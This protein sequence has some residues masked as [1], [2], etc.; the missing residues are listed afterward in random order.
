MKSLVVLS[1]SFLAVI[2]ICKCVYGEWNIIFSGN[3]AMC[4]MLVFTAFWH[5]KFPNCVSMMLPDFIPLKK[6]V[7]YVTGVLEIILGITL[8]IP[9]YRYMAGIATIIFFIMVMPAN[10]TAA[11]KQVDFINA[12]YNNGKTVNYLWFRIPLQLFLLSWVFHFS[13]L[14]EV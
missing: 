9:E 11:F 12:D 10:I 6:I 5:F 3:C 7:V 8:L 13:I 2:A 4:I 14:H 1:A